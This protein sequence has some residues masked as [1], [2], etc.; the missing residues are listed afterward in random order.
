MLEDAEDIVI[1][2]FSGVELHA[3]DFSKDFPGPQPRR[4]PTPH[5]TVHQY[6]YGSQR[7][8]R[9]SPLDVGRRVVEMA[10]TA[11]GWRTMNPPAF[12]C[13]TPQRALDPSPNANRSNS[14][15]CRDDHTFNYTPPAPVLLSDASLACEREWGEPPS[16]GEIFSTTNLDEFVGTDFSGLRFFVPPNHHPE[17]HAAP[18]YDPYAEVHLSGIQSIPHV[19]FPLIDSV[20]CGTQGGASPGPSVI[21]GFAPETFSMNS[22]AEIYGEHHPNPPA[23]PRFERDHPPGSSSDADLYDSAPHNLSQP[24][25]S[26]HFEPSQTDVHR[27]RQ[28]I[29]KFDTSTLLYII[30]E[31]CSHSPIY[32]RLVELTTL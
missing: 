19:P 23:G 13:M 18:E 30:P 6:T 8:L 21:P 2:G 15:I 17:A 7:S 11:S 26:N 25:T 31:V 16:P 1:P 24:R 12:E 14:V 10:T 4:P 28:L 32:V 29:R 5:V 20:P 27:D 3:E 22:G 9:S